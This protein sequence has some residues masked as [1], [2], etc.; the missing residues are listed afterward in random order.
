M[1]Q[2][3]CA[4][5]MLDRLGQWL[6]LSPSLFLTPKQNVFFLVFLLTSNFRVHHFYIN[7]SLKNWKPFC[8]TI[9]QSWNLD[10]RSKTPGQFQKTSE[11]KLCSGSEQAIGNARVGL[12]YN[13]DIFENLNWRPCWR[14]CC[15][16]VTREHEGTERDT[17]SPRFVICHSH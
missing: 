2:I 3:V 15:C 13:P 10:F 8:C 7:N 5:A 1:F 9:M 17:P 16:A 4:C 14:I 11:K 6:R 12:G